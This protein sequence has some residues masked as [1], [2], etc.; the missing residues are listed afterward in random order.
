MSAAFIHSY[1][2]IALLPIAAIFILHTTVG[3]EI[4][5]FLGVQE[6][7]IVVEGLGHS[8]VDIINGVVWGIVYGFV[9]FIIDLIRSRR[10]RN[11]AIEE[12][13]GVKS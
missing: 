10:K 3:Y 2:A 9:G 13:S 5:I 8:W 6:P 4:A 11:S 12:E 7:G 1:I